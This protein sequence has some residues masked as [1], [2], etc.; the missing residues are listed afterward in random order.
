M[1]SRLTPPFAALITAIT[2][3]SLCHADEP[4]RLMSMLAEWQYP[5]SKFNGAVDGGR[6]NGKS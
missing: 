5:D 1:R 3:A 4:V 2:A 6:R